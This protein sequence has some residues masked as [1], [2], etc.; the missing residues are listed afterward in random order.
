MP[1]AKQRFKLQPDTLPLVGRVGEGVATGYAA[2]FALV[3]SLSNHEGEHAARG[4][5]FDKLTMRQRI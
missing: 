5:W 3:V 4:P 2:P 1:S